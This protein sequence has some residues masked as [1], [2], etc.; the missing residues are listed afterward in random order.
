[1]EILNQKLNHK[2]LIV[3]DKLVDYFFLYTCYTFAVYS[4]R[5]ILKRRD[6]KKFKSVIVLASCVVIAGIFLF[7]TFVKGN[8]SGIIITEICPQKCASKKER[9]WIEIYNK[10]SEP[11]DIA[12]W[13]FYVKDESKHTIN[14][15]TLSQNFIIEPGQYAVIAHNDIEFLIEYTDFSGKLYDSTWTRS[16][17][18]NG[19]T[20]GLMDSKEDWVE[21]DFTYKA[22]EKFSL[23]RKNVEGL[24]DDLS[25]WQEHPNGNT[26]GKANYW[27]VQDEN[28]QPPVL[29]N[30]SPIAV[31]DSINT[32]TA[33]TQVLF[34][35]GSSNDPDGDKLTYVW[36]KDDVVIGGAVQ[37]TYTFSA[38][39][40]FSISLIVADTS[41]ATSTAQK[42]FSVL[43]EG[44]IQDPPI[45]TTSTNAFAIII[46]EFVSD[47]VAGE[48][49]W[50]ELY[51]ASTSSVDLHGW[52]LYDG[53]GKIASLDLSLGSN[54]FVLVSLSTSKLNNGGDSIILKNAFGETVDF[55]IYGDWV[56][57]THVDVSVNAPV[58]N[59]PNSVARIVDGQNTGNHKND[60][61]IT[62]KPTPSETNIIITPIVQQPSSSGGGNTQQPNTTIPQ[63]KYSK[64]DI[65]INELVSDP[66]DET[67]EFIELFNTT[68][69]T[70]DLTDWFIEDGSETKTL[71][72]GIITSKG[73]FVLEKPKGALN[74]SGDTVIVFD[75]GG[76]EID[77]VTFGLWDDGN[78]SDNAPAPKDPLSLIR[79]IDGQDANNDYYDF[80]L[81]STITKG[82]ANII[83]GVTKEGEIIEQLVGSAKINISEVF[84][85]PKGSDN[86][87][88]FIE[89]KNIGT[90]TVNIKDWKLG[91]SSTKR[92][93][94]TQGSISPGGYIV[95]KR[96]MTGIALNNTG[97]DE[98]K[99]YASN[100]SLVDSM[101]YPGSVEEDQSYVRRE[102]GSW[103]WTTS[104]T[105]GKE[106]SIEG[107]SAAPVITIDTETEV[108]VNEWITFDASDT[109]DPQ[110]ATLKFSWDFGDG[111][112]EDGSTVQH[113][114]SA[115]GV[116]T[117][118][119]IV[120]N[121][122]KESKKTVAV[123]VKLASD[124][125]GGYG[126]VSDVTRIQIS[127]IFPNP[128]GSDTTEFL[129]LYNLSDE[130]IDLSLLKL[131][132]EEGGSRA[133]TIPQNTLI[134]AGEHKTFG[135]QDTKLA[136]NNTSDSVRI[137]YPDGT[138]LHEVRY[139]DVIEGAS[140]V[141]DS[142]GL[143]IW[144]TQVT[145]GEGNTIEVPV[146]VKGT[147]IT[148][149]SN[150]IAPIIETSLSQLRSE[151]LGDMVKVTGIVAVE[152]GILG[153]Q[154]FYIIDQSQNS[155]STQYA[156]VQIYMYKKDFPK[157]QVGDRVEVSG[158]LAESG[159]EAR[160]KTSE[161]K[162]IV[163]VDHPGEL[164]P[165]LIDITDIGETVE[166]QLV[167]VHGE[168]T[169]IKGS[170]MYVD[171]GTE[172]VKVY[173]KSGAG[174]KK[175]LMQEGNL[176]SISGLVHQTKTEFQLLPR[177]QNDI[178]KTGVSQDFVSKVSS[179]E[180]DESQDLAEKYLTATA[181]GLT[182]I[183]VGL[184]G[185]SHGS[186]IFSFFVFLFD[187][188]RKNK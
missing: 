178:V 154:F 105:P 69:E 43:D 18:N 150:Y 97:G 115:E 113:K 47:P 42:N 171:D 132:D 159:G 10:G 72:E 70:I 102:D 148:K 60:F 126:G 114:F 49:E 92:Y 32:T 133:Y 104:V 181:G 19:D 91:D 84:P 86:E 12:G 37:F 99:L 170:Y 40:T 68:G 129:E 64:G 166:G 117:V 66:S 52:E 98:V 62:T 59:D 56:D 25:N 137:L 63:K 88:E 76:T 61:A 74:N 161:K 145:P 172:E 116:Y 141:R 77:Q 167:Q 123:T 160:I 89:L 164:L 168:I 118:E 16:L 146:Q 147:K 156:G 85:N 2:N 176:V 127:E 184:F 8:N 136:L 14:T 108:A 103:V 36:K 125:V 163:V 7:I 142:E 17:S 175:N 45:I 95:F 50:I 39:G 53:A 26:V 165:H 119:L 185:K 151:D 29:E 5:L 83:S 34:N 3:Y 24:T 94:I 110:G 23:E 155:S 179:Q 22:I 90:E 169:E 101:Q 81:T 183:F 48:K 54:S 93:S 11:V 9:Q 139:D 13:K 21:K 67:E 96:S 140:Y 79:K 124:F 15:T 152:P 162:D 111:L 73:F 65:V 31:I 38:T 58:G 33:G 4:N 78:L 120:S 27:S 30:N 173:F 134:L 75:P 80:V 82:K 46:N 44:D 100:G 143:W 182:A 153:T 186:K 87:N 57:E 41:G 187:K 138:V 177:S 144:T 112:Q 6:M 122:I 130:D 128:I 106:N 35:G 28:G 121:D 55:V 51:N 157:L 188:I 174:I 158:E 109:T 149:K 131:D 20:I 180:K 71:L 107:K 135:R 1:M